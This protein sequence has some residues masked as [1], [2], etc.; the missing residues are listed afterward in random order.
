MTLGADRRGVSILGVFV[1]DLVFSAGRLPAHGETIKGAAFQMGPGGKG[2]NQAV[3]AALAGADVS[4]ITRLG[5]DAFGDMARSL[6]VTAGVTP[7]VA[8]AD[9]PTGAAFV[10]VSTANGENAIIVVPGAASNLCV[11]DVEAASAVIASSKV[12]ATQLE[13]PIPA[14]LRALE[15]ARAHGVTTVFNPAPAEVIP[16]SIYALCDYIVPNETEAAAMVG[17]PLDTIKDAQRAGDILLTRGAGVALI[18]L[19]ERGALFHSRDRSVLVPAYNAGKVVDTTGAGDAFIGGFAA[20]LAR[21]D[22]PLAAADFGCA[23]AGL[24]VTC[25]G[26]AQA[27]PQLQDIQRLRDAPGSRTSS[28]EVER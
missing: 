13:Q 6:W 7:V 23:T 17:R 5:R 15:I 26:T 2:S 20:A 14:A 9:E 11:A 22:E 24:A 4:F 18:T 25:R 28:R 3:A 10:Y 27:M 1:A 19:G 16:D 8:E 12:F 21:G